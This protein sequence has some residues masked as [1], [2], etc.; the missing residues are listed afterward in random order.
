MSD[1][2][3]TYCFPYPKYNNDA[4]IIHVNINIFIAGGNDDGDNVIFEKEP[5]ENLAK[6]N[7][8]NAFKH[9][10]FWKCMD[11][12]RDKVELTDMW[13]KEEALWKKWI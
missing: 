9:D 5:L 10:G 4:I 13:Y 3:F 6:D 2:I 1:F 7:Q 8:I 11:T 12:L